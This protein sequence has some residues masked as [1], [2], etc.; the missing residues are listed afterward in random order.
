MV[1]SKIEPFRVVEENIL[2]IPNFEKALNPNIDDLKVEEKKPTLKY[3][4]N[5]PQYKRSS[6]KSEPAETYIDNSTTLNK[7]LNDDLAN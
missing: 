4:I 3:I 2:K 6:K 7:T 1:E 5:S